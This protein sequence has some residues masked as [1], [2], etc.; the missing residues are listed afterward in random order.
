MWE[1]SSAAIGAP[2]PKLRTDP[3]LRRD[4]RGR[5]GGVAGGGGAGGGHLHAEVRRRG[6][7]GHGGRPLV[8]PVP[9]GTGCVPL[10][11]AP[12]SHLCPR[13]PWF[14]EPRQVL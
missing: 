14:S 12:P 8:A 11:V 7:A 4:R 13:A 10:F 2:Y 6:G 9:Q 1:L 3:L 5:G